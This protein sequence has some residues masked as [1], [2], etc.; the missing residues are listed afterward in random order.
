MPG[1]E[2]RETSEATSSEILRWVTALA[3]AVSHE[4]NNPLTVIVGHLQLLVRTQ[5]LDS[6]GRA[7]VRAALAA[8]VQI[9]ESIRRLALITRLELTAGEPNPPML[10]IETPNPGA[11]VVPASCPGAGD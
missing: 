5:P 11:A 7:R 3:A 6:D 2:A 10:D 1:T 8:A 9:T 4:V